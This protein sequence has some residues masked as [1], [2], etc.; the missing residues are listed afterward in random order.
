MARIIFAIDNGNDL[1]VRARF[2][3]HLDENRALGK[4]HGEA[5]TCIG[6]WADEDGIIWLEQ[7]YCLDER[8]YVELVARHGWTNEQ[9]CVLRVAAD[10]CELLNPQLDVVLS[11]RMAPLVCKGKRMPAGDWTRFD[12]TGDYWVSQ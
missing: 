2:L 6:R 11:A 5:R 12:D 7:S 4:L 1:R 8:D 3:R 10:Y 9:A